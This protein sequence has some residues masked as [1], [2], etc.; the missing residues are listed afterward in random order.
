MR[1]CLDQTLLAL[2]T[3]QVRTQNQTERIELDEAWREIVAQGAGWCARYPEELRKAFNADSRPP[4]PSASASPSRFSELTLVADAH[5]VEGIESARLLQHVLPLV[6]RGISELDSLVSSAIGQATVRPDLNPLRPEVFAQALR[7]VIGPTRSNGPAVSSWMNHLALPLGREL[8]AIYADLVAQLQRANVQ[9]AGYAVAVAAPASPARAPG[10]PPDSPVAGPSTKR[11]P[12]FH[13]ELSSRQFSHALLKGFLSDGLGSE[14]TRALPQSYYEEIDRELAQ[15]RSQAESEPAPPQPVTPSYRA[16]PAVDRPVRSVGLQSSL[17]A[18]V[19]G[20]YAGSR[21]RALVRTQLRKDATQVGQALGLELVRKVVN[22]VAHDPRL[23]APVR[24]AIVALE[25]SLLRLSMSDPR[26]LTE[27][28]HPGRQLMERVAQRSFK[29]NDEFSKE[30]AGFFQQVGEQF[31][32][33]N[34]LPIE[35]AEPF[36]EALQQL[37]TRWLQGDEAEE[38]RQRLGMEAVRFAEL[39]QAEADLIAL[40]LRSRPDLD[41]VPEAIQKFLF[42]SWSLVM[43]HARLTDRQNRVDPQGYEGVIT[44]LLWSVKREVTLKQPAQLFQRIPALVATLRA[45][46]VSIGQDPADNEPFFEA[47]MQLHHPVLKLRRAKSRL[48]ARKSGAPAPMR[49]SA[50]GA[51]GAVQ[52]E[53]PAGLPWMSPRELDQAGFAD[54]LPS[55]PAELAEEAPPPPLAAPAEPAAAAPA[56]PG[57]AAISAQMHAPPEAQAL[58]LAAVAESPCDPQEVLSQLREGTWV[59]LYSKRRWLRAQLVWASSKGTLFMF[60]SHGGQPH[61][62]TKRSCQRLIQDR[63]LRPVR[64]DAVVEQALRTLSRETAAT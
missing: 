4:P 24:E 36:E 26:F 10:S 7:V 41:Q 34:Q 28:S 8:Q 51:P 44:D 50:S 13:R 46:L 40:K 30:F 45:G 47:L 20:T 52:K 11:Q 53:R 2:Q 32:G 49:V 54:T 57:E 23:L 5:I 22:E 59:D 1:R 31:N 17:D 16:L 61:S 33:L 58:P 37:E 62:M 21:E 18:K 3:A 42:G 25:P 39:R 64:T 9:A 35:N 56:A 15:L 19:W 12:A 63:F 48:D 43:A 14:A 38:E 55:S 29:Y 60:V 6:E 27:E